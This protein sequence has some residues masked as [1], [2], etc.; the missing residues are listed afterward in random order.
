MGGWRGGGWWWGGGGLSS[1]YLSRG[2]NGY[3]WRPE[4][5]GEKGGRRWEVRGVAERGVWS[6][7]C[8]RRGTIGSGEGGCA[9]R[10]VGK[11]CG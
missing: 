4:G 11:G 2:K 1:L 10:G 9:V 6:G 8:G 3:G 5:R 7:R